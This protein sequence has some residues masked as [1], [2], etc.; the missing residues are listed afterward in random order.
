MCEL[1]AAALGQ[2]VRVSDIENRLGGEGHTLTALRA[3]RAQ[4]PAHEFRLVVGADIEAEMQLWH[5]A[6]ELR[7]ETPVIVVGRSGYGQRDGLAM[8]AVSSTEVRVRI[9]RGQSVA[10]L[11]PR[12]VADYIREQ[13]LYST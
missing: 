9:K 3:L 1:A 10:H 7:R 4:H 6:D 12:S 2:R 13:L 11:V 5:G 8:P